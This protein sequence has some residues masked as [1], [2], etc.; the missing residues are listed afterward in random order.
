MTQTNA[1]GRLFFCINPVVADIAAWPAPDLIF[2]SKPDI[3]DGRGTLSA[4]LEKH[5]YRITDRRPAFTVWA[6]PS[7]DSTEATK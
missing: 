6:K 4:Y 7:A 2:Q 5:R 3:F 1:P